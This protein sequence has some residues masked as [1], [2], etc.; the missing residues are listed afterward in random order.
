MSSIVTEDFLPGRKLVVHVAQ[1][2]HT[3]ELDCDE[4]TPVEAIQRYIESVSGIQFNDQ[5]LLCQDMKLEPQRPLSAYKLPCDDRELFLYNRARLHQ[6]SPHPPS[7]Q[8]D[9][10][11]IVDPPLPSSSQNPHPLDDALDPALKVLPSYER[12]FRYHFQRGGAIYDC[13]EVKFDVCERFLREQRV[14]E[15]ALETAKGS[16]DHIYRMVHQTYMDFMKCFLQQQR[17]HSDLLANFGRDMEKLRSCKLHP[18]LQSESRKCLLDFV[19]EENLRKWVENCASSHKQF[20][21][22]VSHLKT[23]F[24]ELKRRV[25]DL[26][27]SKATASIRDVDLMIK[28]HK[29]YLNE[30]KSIMQSLS[31][32]VNTVKKLVDD[33]LSC[34]LSDSLRPH[35][36]VSALGPMYDVHDKNHLPKMEGCERAI[37]KLLDF[38]K[39]KKNEMNLFVHNFMQ[40]V[41]YVQFMV[42]DVRLQFPAFK[43][44]M[45]RQDDLFA[46]LKL[47]RGIGP[48]YRACFAEVVWRRASMKL[49]MG[50]AGQL[51]ERLASKREIEVRRRDEFLKAQSIYIPRDILASMGLF[52]SPNHCDVNIAPFDTNLLEIDIVD[53]D[54]YAPES[55]LRMPYKGEKHTLSKSL[56]SISS[57]NSHLDEAE[58]NSAGTH[59]KCD[60]EELLEGCESINIA[61]TSKMEV[62]NA[63]LKAELAA[64]VARICSFGPEIEY[65]SLDDSKLDNLVKNTAEKTAEALHLKD[66][67]GKH[68]QSVLK[69]KHMQ[70]MSYE[71]RIQELER[72]LSECTLSSLKTYDCKSEMSGDGEAHMPMDEV[73]CTSVS[74]D[75]KL[76]QFSGQLGEPR[77]GADENMTE[78]S[79]M[80]NQQAADSIHTV[81]DSSMLEPRQDELQV[82]DKAGEEKM[83]L[84]MGSTLTNSFGSEIITEPLRVLPSGVAGEPFS[85]LKAK[86]DL[87]LEL[88]SALADKSNQFNETENK[89]KATME[90]VATLKKE[91]ETSRKLLDESQM[92]CAHLENCLH[93]AREEAHTNLCA[94][95]RRASEYSALHSSALK[96]CALFERLRSCVTASGGVATFADSLRSLA[97]SVNNENE[98]N[99]TA[100]F[101]TSMRVL[102]DKVGFL[103]RQRADLLERCSKLETAHAHLAEELEEKKELVKTLYAKHQF[104]KQVSKEKISLGRFEVHELA[105]FVLNSAGRYEAINLN[106]SNYYLSTESVALFVE[107]L[108]S[109]PSYIIGQIVH[110]ERQTVR[111]STSVQ[112]YHGDQVDPMI[113]DLVKRS[114]PGSGST[115]NPY[116]LPIGCEYFIVTVAMLPDTI[117]SPPS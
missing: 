65:D 64:A 49:Y 66:E 47:V 69:I 68:L 34:Q 108:P 115:W 27:S 15:K 56:L 30:Q 75:P 85:A 111:P 46:D 12:Q 71:K 36:A 90:E 77:E 35:D 40:K 45:A 11:E 54:R 57:D 114:A 109:R 94:A 20:E 18:A 105:A 62:E 102:A 116:D 19:K 43:E 3:Y 5:L 70:C 107:N 48:A 26:L 41:A 74:L 101:G 31:K 88:Q 60:S 82:V 37:S 113:S 58:L 7:E 100:E 112:T 73:S 33:C 4:S 106:C 50:M 93:E 44:A 59:E 95:E 53:L 24:T 10:S 110:I 29:R 25:G 23:M 17:Y 32:D 16:M 96:M 86:D 79:G 91:M 8:I 92:N 83:A 22:K 97:S 13:A 78:F 14:Q 98:D 21:L 67:Y 89:L 117:H 42:R 104:E 51:A 1:N 81:M 9:I 38:C 103:S 2:G 6:D 84:Q 55:L 63:R 76:E 80:L 72:R 39:V 28:E 87:L 99:G 61:G 52:D